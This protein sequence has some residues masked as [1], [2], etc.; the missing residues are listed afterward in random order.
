MTE[1]EIGKVTEFFARPVGGWYS[2]NRRTEAA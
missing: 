1:V 2:V